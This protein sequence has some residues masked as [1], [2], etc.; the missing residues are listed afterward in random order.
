MVPAHPLSDLRTRLEALATDTGRFSVSCARTGERPVPVAGRRFPDRAT[1]RTAAQVATAYRATLRRYDPQTPHY[2]L[3]V[4]E[5]PAAVG[6]ASEQGV[7]RSERHAQAPALA[8]PSSP[9]QEPAPQCVCPAYCTR[10]LDAVCAA[11]TARGH[12][13]VP[14]SRMDAAVDQARAAATPVRHLATTAAQFD[15]SVSPGDHPDL[16]AAAAARLASSRTD[17]TPL[18]ATLAALD[19]HGLT[20]STARSP[21]SVDLDDGERI[22]VVRLSGYA[23]APQAGR[24]P[25]LP[26]TLELARHTTGRLSESITAAPDEDGWRLTIHR[27]D[28]PTPSGLL[29]A[30]ITE[31]W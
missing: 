4:R 24:L 16:L 15:A 12:D 31:G 13:A 26:I 21:W 22:V 10:L 27:S 8:P 29:A 6:D 2:D 30:P 11:G 9:N 17:D 19:A 28:P 25:T 1:A 3:I 14:A 23:L 20:A 5:A 7:C 18:D